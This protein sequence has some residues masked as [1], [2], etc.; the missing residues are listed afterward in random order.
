MRPSFPRAPHPRLP[1]RIFAACLALSLAALPGGAGPR[2]AAGD[3]KAG[4][5]DD[6]K[7]PPGKRVVIYRLNAAMQFDLLLL[8]DKGN[9]HKLTY[10][11]EDQRSNNLVF[12]AIDGKT[13]AFGVKADAKR[14]P[15]LHGGKWETKQAPL[16][17]GPDGKERLGH[18]S[19]WLAADKIRIT[20]SL[21][22]VPSKDGSLDAC[23][24]RYEVENTDDKPHKVA[25]RVVVDVYVGKND[26]P[27]FMVPG[28]KLIT[29]S[30]DLRGKDVPYAA[31]A[32]EKPD[33]KSPGVVGYFTLRPG[34]KLEGPDRFT[35]TQFPSEENIKDLLKWEIPVR[36]MKLDAKD[37]GDA[38][39]VMYWPERVLKGGARRAMGFAYGGGVTADAQVNG[40]PAGKEKG[41]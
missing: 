37:P 11:A 13:Y 16:G 26:A 32:M 6:A 28:G 21:E 2:A 19:V 20:Q 5:G 25:M 35:V 34:R 18:K 23:L 14:P 15:G 39:V 40:R 36:N 24:I 27:A 9:R 10:A 31:K 41:R 38:A 8:D 22:V 30:A 7:A 17:K 4:K 1:L 12:F 3:K 29:T 33:V